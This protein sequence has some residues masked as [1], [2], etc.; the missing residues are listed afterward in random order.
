M[1][2]HRPR[3][4]QLGNFFVGEAELLEHFVSMLALRRRRRHDLAWCARKLHWLTDKNLLGTVGTLRSL[5]DTDVLDLLVREHLIDCINRP[6]WHANLVEDIYPFGAGLV[7]GPLVDLG[8]ERV[9][10]FRAQR[11]GRVIGMLDQL[12]GLKCV[13]QPFPHHL[14]GRRDIDMAVLRLE[15]SGWNAGRMVVAG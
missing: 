1:A 8:V 13:A 9:A 6:A 3:L 4:V 15:Y 5:R 12:R 7:H 10:V 11:S 2:L 14:A